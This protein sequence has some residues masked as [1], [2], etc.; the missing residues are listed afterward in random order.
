VLR[1]SMGQKLPSSEKRPRY[2]WCP[3]N[4]VSSSYR[5]S[6]AEDNPAMC[7][8]KHNIPSSAEVK[9][10]WGPTFDTEPAPPF[11]QHVHRHFTY[12]LIT[13]ALHTHFRIFV[14][15]GLC[16][17]QT[18]VTL[19]RT[20]QTGTETFLSGNELPT[21]EFLFVSLHLMLFFE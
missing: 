10:Q 19:K 11:L 7:E 2:I 16:Q 3:P 4:L 5:V 1:L 21:G 18:K 13:S 8:A 12:I 14:G 6:I 17:T 20:R 9:K 15:F